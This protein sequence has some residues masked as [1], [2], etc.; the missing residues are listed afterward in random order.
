MARCI[1]PFQRGLLQS[2]L[3]VDIAVSVK[4]G[5]RRLP[6]KVGACAVIF[7]GQTSESCKHVVYVWRC[8]R[9]KLR[10]ITPNCLS[11]LTHWIGLDG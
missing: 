8:V 1:L 4:A 5:G 9:D 11:A 7:R 6:E 2:L 10:D 3:E